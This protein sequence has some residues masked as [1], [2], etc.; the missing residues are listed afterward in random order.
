LKHFPLVNQKQYTIV[1]LKQLAGLE[2]GTEV[3][4]ASLLEAGIITVAKGPLKVLG[5]GELEQALT[6]KAAA[7]TNSAQTKIEAAKGTC[8]LVSN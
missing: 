6:V 1:N 7:F 4:L 8:E 3:T 2:A 5:D